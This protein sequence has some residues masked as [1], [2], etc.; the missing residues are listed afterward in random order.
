MLV[1]PGPITDMIGA[2]L[3]LL[4]VL[5]QRYSCKAGSQSL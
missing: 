1:M 5:F 3:F 4:L 2:G